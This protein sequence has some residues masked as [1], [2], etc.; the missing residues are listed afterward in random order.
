MVFL[1]SGGSVNVSQGGIV[2]SISGAAAGAFNVGQSVLTTSGSSN[3]FVTTQAAT[4]NTLTFALLQPISIQLVQQEQALRKTSF[5]LDQDNERAT[6]SGGNN[7]AAKVSGEVVYVTHVNQALTGVIA[8]DNSLAFA[9]Q[10]TLVSQGNGVTILHK[11]R[12][13]VDTGEK[14]VIVQ[15]AAG[16][17]E[18]N[19]NSTM[20]V[21]APASGK[22]KVLALSG[23]SK[24]EIGGESKTLESGKEFIAGADLSEDE[25][26]PADGIPCGEW[27]S[28]SMTRARAYTRVVSLKKVVDLNV[29]I[30][31]SLV[32]I[33]GA[34]PKAHQRYIGRVSQSANLQEQFVAIQAPVRKLETVTQP[35]ATTKNSNFAQSS[36]SLFANENAQFQMTEQGDMAITSGAITFSAPQDMKI[37]TPLATV[38]ALKG[39]C[40]SIEASS[41]QT[42]VRSLSGMK[43][44]KVHVGQSTVLL[45]GG[46]EL[47]V[48]SRMIVTTSDRISRRN[49][50]KF[51][52]GQHFGAM[53]EFSIPSFISSSSYMTALAHPSS[54][55]SK[56]L[57]QRMLKTAAALQFAVRK[58]AY[59]SSDPVSMLPGR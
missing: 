29:M 51:P 42:K 19:Q 3:T 45:S 46:E 56:Q 54:P 53:S 17:V 52:L 24:L 44:V 35:H 11:G 49:S 18:I 23:S 5:N 14:G 7:K 16:R 9:D 15:T 20:L 33:G 10:D 41:D 31:G 48:S 57:Q 50:S 12:M 21:E 58:G 34:R 55:T 8:D 47:V 13:V 27:V 40:I 38:D 22:M 6:S 37:T 4:V 25:M 26:V 59:R 28:A 30:S 32:H 39:T 36:L 1:S 43:S 2:G